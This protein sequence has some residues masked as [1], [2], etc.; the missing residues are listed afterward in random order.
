V[1][2][3]SPTY[4]LDVFA[5]LSSDRRYLTV[6]VVNATETAQPLEL[7]LSGRT[8]AGPATLWQITAANLEAANHVGQPPQVEL[9]ESP[10]AAA[11]SLTVA[12]I[13]INVYRFPV[14]D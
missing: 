2:S 14:T 9:K 1:N 13:S 5:A 4:P 10:V 3:G 7:N 11:R 12:P 8:L 6:A